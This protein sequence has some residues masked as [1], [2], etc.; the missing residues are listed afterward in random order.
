MKRAHVTLRDKEV[1]SQVPFSQ[2]PTL[3][4]CLWHIVII[5]LIVIQIVFLHW[6][7]G[8]LE[9]CLSAFACSKSTLKIPEQYMNAAQS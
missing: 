5:F 2:G 6:N 1:F 4:M 7:D 8:N 3:T 9:I